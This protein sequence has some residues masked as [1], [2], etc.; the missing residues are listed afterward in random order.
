MCPCLSSAVVSFCL[1]IVCIYY[2]L[3]KKVSLYFCTNCSSLLLILYSAVSSFIGVQRYKRV[4]IIILHLPRIKALS[5]SD[6]HFNT[7]QEGS[8]QHFNTR[9]EGSDP[10]FNTRQE[11]SDWHFNTKKEGSDHHFNTR[12][13]GSDRHFNTRQKGRGWNRPYSRTCASPSKKKGQS[14]EE[15]PLLIVL[16]SNTQAEKKQNNWER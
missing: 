8:D 12:Q 14:P 7:R 9:Q 16:L 6:C 1:F 10:H 2:T 15:F 4:I 11:G 13:E 3:K 5:V